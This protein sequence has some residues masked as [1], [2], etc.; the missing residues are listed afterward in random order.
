MQLSMEGKVRNKKGNYRGNT[1]RRK[2]KETRVG[3]Q[4]RRKKK[5]M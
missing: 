2:R 4:N 3:K 1:N 5:S